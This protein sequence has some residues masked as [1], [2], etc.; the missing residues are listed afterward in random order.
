MEKRMRED[1]G[2]YRHRIEAEE[3]LRRESVPVHANPQLQ[4]W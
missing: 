4:T 2:R 3:D 1:D